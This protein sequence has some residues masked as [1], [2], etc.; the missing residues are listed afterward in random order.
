MHQS[1]LC[2]WDLASAITLTRARARTHTHTH[3][4]THAHIHTHAGIE[5][6]VATEAGCQQRG[7]EKTTV[8]D[9][10]KLLTHTPQ[11]SLSRTFSGHSS[12]VLIFS[13]ASLGSKNP[14]DFGCQNSNVDF[15]F[16]FFV[17]LWRV[18]G[19]I[20]FFHQPLSGQNIQLTSDSRSQMYMSAFIFLLC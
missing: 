9:S 2:C 5:R 7:H 10:G 18:I 8:L 20:S 3:T 14:A 12:R 11:A 15:P 4:H 6:R 1:L 16:Y 13:P 19:E 17:M